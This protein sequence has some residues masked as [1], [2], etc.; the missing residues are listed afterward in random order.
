MIVNTFNICKDACLLAHL[1]D[2]IPTK[3]FILK[4]KWR[5]PSLSELTS[6]IFDMR[7][8]RLGSETSKYTQQF[9]LKIR[10]L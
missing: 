5:T 4:Y 8:T 7:L 9:S 10:H 1:A 6:M 2:Q 3:M